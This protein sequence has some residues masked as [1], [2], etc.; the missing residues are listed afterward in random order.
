MRCE[1]SE[2]FA[3]AGVL[4]PERGAE[5][6]QPCDGEMRLGNRGS[7]KS[8]RQDSRCV[9]LCPVKL[10]G[11][12]RRQ[13]LRKSGQTP[14]LLILCSL[15]LARS[16]TLSLSLSHPPSLPPSPP[17]SSCTL[18]GGLLSLPPPSKTPFWIPPHICDSVSGVSCD[19]VIGTWPSLFLGSRTAGPCPSSNLCYLCLSHTADLLG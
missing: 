14:H 16:L 17:L 9:Q 10:Y 4:G 7:C 11:L 1:I 5:A 3:D 12:R 18:S 15:S 19:A 8:V 6:V 13:R 2:P